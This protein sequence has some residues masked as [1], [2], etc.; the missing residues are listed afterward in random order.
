MK[1]LILGYLLNYLKEA[2][3]EYITELIEDLLT[4]D[5][6]REVFIVPQ[7]P[8]GFL[9][10]TSE[11][12][13]TKANLHGTYKINREDHEHRSNSRSEVVSNVIPVREFGEIHFFFP[14]FTSYVGWQTN[15]ILDGANIKR[16]RSYP[17]LY[18]LGSVYLESLFSEISNLPF[19]SE[20]VHL[21]RS[22]S[23]SKFN[24]SWPEDFK[25]SYLNEEI[26]LS[27]PDSFFRFGPLTSMLR[28][29]DFLSALWDLEETIHYSV[30]VPGKITTYG[31]PAAIGIATNNE[32]P[33]LPEL[34]EGT[35]G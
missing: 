32:P 24:D 1:A 18:K 25:G 19:L 26:T 33:E 7:Y 6:V 22:K 14:L 10:K 9:L 21:N 29:N 34:P 12:I 16:F 35:L 20:P 28:S 4:F 8:A 5:N 11:T 3:A 27:S 30:E 13:I 17:N 15:E 23:I 31:W 2:A